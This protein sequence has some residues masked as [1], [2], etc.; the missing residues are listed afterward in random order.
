MNTLTPADC[1]YLVIILQM[2]LDAG[3]LRGGSAAFRPE[4]RDYILRLIQRLRNLEN[5]LNWANSPDGQ[6]TPT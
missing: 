5:D 4:S 2:C 3:R 1:D 6:V